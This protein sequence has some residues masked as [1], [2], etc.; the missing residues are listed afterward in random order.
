MH[1][2]HT[3]IDVQHPDEGVLPDRGLQGPVDT[4]HDP[5]EELGVDVLGEGVPGVHSL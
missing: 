4:I 2:T 5:A 3:P 1:A